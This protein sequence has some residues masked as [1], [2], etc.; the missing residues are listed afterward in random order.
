MS[1][2]PEGERKGTWIGCR[3]KGKGFPKDSTGVSISSTLGGA[4]V[5]QGA[6]RRAQKSGNRI[7]AVATSLL[8]KGSG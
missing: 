6:Y 5:F 3:R 2:E 8:I 4:G 7:S 1:T